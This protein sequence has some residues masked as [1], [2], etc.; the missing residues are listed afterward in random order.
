MLF[1]SPADV[2]LVKQIETFFTVL[3]SSMQIQIVTVPP[4]MVRMQ[5]NS[6]GLKRS[7]RLR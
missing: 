2:L 3:F 6:I 5:G 7:S 1:G 4:R